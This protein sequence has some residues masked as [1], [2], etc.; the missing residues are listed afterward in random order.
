MTAPLVVTRLQRRALETGQ[1][2][3]SGSFT[4]A[5]VQ[6]PVVTVEVP[7]PRNGKPALALTMVMR[8][9]VFLT[10]FEEWNLSEGWLAGLR[11]C[12]GTSSGITKYPEHEAD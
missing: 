4:K 1:F 8:P 6:T 9:D 5:P 3:I 11:V 10:L 7:V 2:Q 12:P